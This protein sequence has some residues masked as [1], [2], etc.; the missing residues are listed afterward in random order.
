[1][2]LELNL[3]AF[4]ELVVVLV[5]WVVAEAVAEAMVLTGLAKMLLSFDMMR[6]CESAPSASLSKGLL[7]AW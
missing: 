4:S 3:T 5:A 2:N 7:S 1:L 6:T